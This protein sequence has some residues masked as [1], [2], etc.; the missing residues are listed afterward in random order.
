MSNIK[1]L[2][3]EVREQLQLCGAGMRIVTHYDNNELIL[4]AKDATPDVQ[5]QYLN[6]YWH[7]Q[8]MGLNENTINVR[9]CLVTGGSVDDWLRLFKG[10]VVPCIVRNDLPRAIA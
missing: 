4:V 1:C 7:L 6:R 8:L 10:T 2:I 3:S 9:F 5:R